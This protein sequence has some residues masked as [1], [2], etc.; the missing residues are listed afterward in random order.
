MNCWGWATWK[1]RWQKF[2]R[3]PENLIN[4]FSKEDIYRFNVDGK[5]NFLGSSSCE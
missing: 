4:E 3:N 2:E 1:D 5:H